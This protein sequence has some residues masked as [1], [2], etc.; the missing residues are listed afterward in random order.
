MV[1][2]SAL[3]RHF[4]GDGPLDERVGE[5]IDGAANGMLTTYDAP[6]LALAGRA[7][8]HLL[9]ADAKLARAALAEMI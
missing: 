1:D 2:T 4:L 9:T 8:A 3:L 6:F 5:A 7:S